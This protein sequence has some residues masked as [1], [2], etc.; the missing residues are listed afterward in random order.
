MK[1]KLI[2]I[3]LFLLVIL[4]GVLISMLFLKP[5][6]SNGNPHKKP[7][8]SE[9]LAFSKS[10]K[11]D[12]KIFDKL[13]KKNMKLLDVKIMNTKEK[14]F[15]SLKNGDY[16]ID[17]LAL[18]IGNLQEKKEI[19]VFNFFKKIR[20]LCDSNQKQKFDLIIKKA[21]R[22]KTPFLPPRGREGMPPPPR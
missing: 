6:N 11:S 7:F 20:N 15:Y 3:L 19:E 8:L 22:N 2:L 9:E 1:S 5:E 18:I 13:H 21:L 17:S 14:L 4:N 16:K 12:F 10:Q